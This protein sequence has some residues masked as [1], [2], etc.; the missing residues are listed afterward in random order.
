MRAAVY[1]KWNQKRKNHQAT[2]SVEQRLAKSLKVMIGVSRLKCIFDRTL[3][4]L[5]ASPPPLASMDPR[6]GSRSP[7]SGGHHILL[8]TKLPGYL[9]LVIHHRLT[10]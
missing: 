8:P 7:M 4:K 10:T 9:C 5:K 3:R 6:T 1:G 2:V